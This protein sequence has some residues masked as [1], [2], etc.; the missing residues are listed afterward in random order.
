MSDLNRPDENRLKAKFKGVLDHFMGTDRL[1]DEHTGSSRLGFITP[2]PVDSVLTTSRLTFTRAPQI[3]GEG[4]SLVC[5]QCANKFIGSFLCLS[6]SQSVMQGA[7]NFIMRD[8]AF[9]V[10]QNVC[11]AALMV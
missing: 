6:E 10:A 1:H 4:T 8:S 2:T 5:L 11:P 7:N 3:T 9:Y